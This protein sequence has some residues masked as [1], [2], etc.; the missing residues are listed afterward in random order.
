MD[1][2]KV[3]R[4]VA[5]RLGPEQHRRSRCRHEHACLR[6]QVHL[7]EPHALRELM[8]P[9]TEYRAYHDEL[10]GEPLLTG[11]RS[12]GGVGPPGPERPESRHWL[13]VLDQ[14]LAATRQALDAAA[15]GPGQRA[16]AAA[17]ASGGI[18]V[19]QPRAVVR[20]AV[21]GCIE[22]DEDDRWNGAGNPQVPQ[23]RRRGWKRPAH[24]RSLQS[25]R[26][27]GAAGRMSGVRGMLP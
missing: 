9:T 23:V 11:G 1:W 15:T 21:P 22:V 26:A 4:L 20:H 2:W 18:R 17:P 25:V 14:A 16:D 3:R 6:L 27:V 24:R 10:T 7:T 19:R 12:S 5:A 8:A 13:M